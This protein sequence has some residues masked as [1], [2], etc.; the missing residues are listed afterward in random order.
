LNRLSAE[1]TRKWILI[2]DDDSSVRL[3]LARVLSDEGYGVL[4]A[5]NGLDALGLAATMSF[6]LVLLDLN[7]PGANGWKTLKEMDTKTLASSVI[8]I[9]A[10]PNQQAA[11]REA[12]VAGLLEKP[13]DFPRLLQMVS[14]VLARTVASDHSA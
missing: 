1:D 4:T 3:M 10:M 5:A 7:M 12:G 2:V 14:E 6:D 8:I 11:A 13:L 9:T